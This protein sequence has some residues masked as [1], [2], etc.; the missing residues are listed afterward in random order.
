M[1]SMANLFTLSIALEKT[2]NTMDNYCNKVNKCIF[3]KDIMKKYKE[4]IKK[5]NQ[6]ENTSSK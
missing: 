5:L 4:M 6:D 2:T 3:T 1:C